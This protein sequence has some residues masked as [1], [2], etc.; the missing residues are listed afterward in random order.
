MTGWLIRLSLVAAAIAMALVPMSPTLVERYYSRAAYPALQHLVT[1][2]SNLVPI[3]LLD[4]LI[5][6]A[7]VLVVM[8]YGRAAR[9]PRGQRLRRAGRTTATLVAGGCALYV[10]FLVCWGLNYRRQ[11]VSAWLEFDEARVTPEAARDLASTA[12]R[13]M[14]R[15]R[16]EIPA[17]LPDRHRELTD[18]TTEALH[19]SLDDATALLGLPHAV[20][21]GR[22]KFTS[23]DLYFTRAGVS[24]MTDPFF[25]ETMAASNLLPWERP[26]VLAHEWAHLAGFARESEAA[27]VSWLICMRADNR[28]QYSGWMDLFLRTVPS[29]GRGERQAVMK[30]LTAAVMADLDAMARRTERDHVRWVSL[31]AWRTY[32]SYLRANRVESGVRNY[33]EVV[34]LVL[35]T[36]FSGDWKPVLRPGR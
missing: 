35:G 18:S 16:A 19:R 15:F 23:L 34:R 25:L 27:F 5:A 21:P 11:P 6:G 32:D 20:I 30:T 36:R 13:E 24:G 3:A 33:N 17:W 2:G 1:T 7:V 22:P 4:V 26:A 29:L 31:A 14:G 28:A 9:A 12:A 8:G 10:C